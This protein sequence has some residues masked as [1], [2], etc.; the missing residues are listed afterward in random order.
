MWTLKRVW[1]H[2]TS[3]FPSSKLKVPWGVKVIGSTGGSSSE[4]SARVKS[5]KVAMLKD[6]DWVAVDPGVVSVSRAVADSSGGD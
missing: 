2:N 1:T 3:T 4:V 6:G 5:D